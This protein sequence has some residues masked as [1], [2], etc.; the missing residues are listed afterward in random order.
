MDFDGFFIQCDEVKMLVDIDSV[1]APELQPARMEDVVDSLV[2]DSKK[3]II[4]IPK[5]YKKYDEDQIVR[6]ISIIQVEVLYS[7]LV[8][9]Y[10]SYYYKLFLSDAIEECKVE[11]M[12]YSTATEQYDV[13]CSSAYKLLNVFSASFSSALHGA[14]KHAMKYTLERNVP[15]AVEARFN[16]LG[17]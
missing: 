13:P 6:F 15:R 2:E 17:T 4:A 1:P 16:A 9:F 8:L 5:N 14:L 11:C 12:L 7:A 3:V 10:Y